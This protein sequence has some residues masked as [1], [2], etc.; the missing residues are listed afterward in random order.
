MTESETKEKILKR[1]RGERHPKPLVKSHHGQENG[2]LREEW[3][4]VA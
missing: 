2:I 1:W 4:Y 3:K